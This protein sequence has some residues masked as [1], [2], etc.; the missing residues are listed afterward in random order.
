MKIMKYVLF[1]M[2]TV[3]MLG[4]CIEEDL[5]DC[6]VFSRNVLTLSYKGD[7]TTEIFNEKIENV[8]MYV[9]DQNEQ[10]V[11]TKELTKEEI[12]RRLVIVPE[13]SPAIYRVICFGNL[14]K[15]QVN[16][17]ACGDCD[18]MYC[19]APEYFKKETIS[20][21]DSLYYASL[22]LIVTEEDQ[23]QTLVF[24]SSHYKVSV[25]VVGVPGGGIRPTIEL[26]GLSPYTNFENRAGGEPTT[27]VLKSEYDEGQLNAYTNI[28]RHTNHEAVDVCVRDVN[29]NDL[30]KINLAEFLTANPVIDVVKNEV[31]IPIRLEFKSVGIE[32]SVPEWYI[33][34]VK[35]EF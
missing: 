25:E 19:A 4:G 17:L 24:T 12:A 6:E 3:E 31:L 33:E 21:N 26:C 28:M 32:V 35:P 10:L 1:I 15:C 2:L 20:G 7:G 5:S 14:M 23:N 9:F 18:K 22:E 11:T 34:Q 16:D 13:L 29:G 27:Y 8:V 30:A